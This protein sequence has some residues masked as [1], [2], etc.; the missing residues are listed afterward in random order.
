MSTNVPH[1]AL[2]LFG[3]SDGKELDSLHGHPIQ[4]EVCGAMICQDKKATICGM[5]LTLRRW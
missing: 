5:L 3:I 4:P 2:G 1:F